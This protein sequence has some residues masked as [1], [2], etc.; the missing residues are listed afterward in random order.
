MK[1]RQA[2][3]HYIEQL[4]PTTTADRR[5]LVQ[6]ALGTLLGPALD[7]PVTALT[8]LRLVLLAGDLKAR[9]SSKTGRPLAASTFRRYILIGQTFA[10][11]ASARWPRAAKQP[12]QPAA[13]QEPA[14]KQH[15]GELIRILRTDAGLTRQQLGDS[16]IGAIVLKRV[17]TGRQR[18]NKKQLDK[19]LTAP[20]MDRLLDWAAREGMGGLLAWAEVDLSPGEDGGAQ[21]E[22]GSG[23]GEDGGNDRGSGEQGKGGGA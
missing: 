14:S 15:L 12:G 21:G 18:L 6:V 10:A 22:D 11:W 9:T 16:T 13:E 8:N 5:Q 20:C 23:P 1:V 2:I 19:L 4:P 7:E 3:D 17:E